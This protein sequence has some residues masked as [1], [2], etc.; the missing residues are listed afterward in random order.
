MSK[1]CR[2]GFLIFVLVFGSRDLELG[3]VPLVSPSTQVFPIS[4]WIEVDD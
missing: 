2:A 1:F 3:G 4:L